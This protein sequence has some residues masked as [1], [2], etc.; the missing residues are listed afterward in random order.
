VMLHNL[1]ANIGSRFANLFVGGVGKIQ[2]TQT[3]LSRSS[4]LEQPP[5]FGASRLNVICSIKPKVEPRLGRNTPQSFFKS[6][7]LVHLR[8]MSKL[9]SLESISKM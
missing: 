1:N 8:K 6:L 7:S 3:Q 9:C 4:R 5:A 2:A